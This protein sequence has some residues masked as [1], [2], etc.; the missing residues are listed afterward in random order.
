[1]IQ[2]INSGN[3]YVPQNKKNFNK[4]GGGFQKN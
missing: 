3:S 1:M 2:G 4:A